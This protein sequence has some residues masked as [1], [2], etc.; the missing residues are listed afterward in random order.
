MTFEVIRKRHSAVATGCVTTLLAWRG[1]VTLLAAPWCGTLMAFVKPTSP[2][3]PLYCLSFLYIVASVA[4]MSAL[5]FVLRVTAKRSR[6]LQLEYDLHTVA[7]RKVDELKRSRY[8]KTADA[9]EALLSIGYDPTEDAGKVF[10]C[11]PL[12]Q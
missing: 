3:L 4:V 9:S 1:L 12:T 8:A 5:V 11:L 10:G 6:A 7:E 2:V